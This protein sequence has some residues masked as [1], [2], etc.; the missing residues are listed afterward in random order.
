MVESDILENLFD[1]KILHI[2]REFYAQ[3]QHQFYLREIAKLTSVSVAT[4]FRILNRLVEL[5]I[6]E[7]VTAGTTK[8]YKL[9][10]TEATRFLGQFVKRHK[11]VLQIFITK[12]KVIPG[13]QSVI[14]H[15]KDEQERADVLLIGTLDPEFVKSICGDIHMNYHYTITPLILSPD[16]YNQMNSMGL[17]P[18]KKF[19][20]YEK[21]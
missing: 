9:A 1:Q 19:V 21:T 10:D 14:L 8:L 6:L 4:T 5:S 18:N 12:V 11:Q 16:Q 15:G 13:L 17:L 2:L 7:Q 20:L 3:D